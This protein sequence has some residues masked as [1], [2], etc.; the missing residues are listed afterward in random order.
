VYLKTGI[1][2]SAL[3]NLKMSMDFYEHVHLRF[4]IAPFLDKFY[5]KNF[6]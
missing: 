2:A 6:L 5:A 4:G 3:E 1:S